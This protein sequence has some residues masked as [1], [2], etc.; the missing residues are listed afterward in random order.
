ML[1]R[2]FVVLA[3]LGSAAG[4]TASPKGKGRGAAAGKG[5]GKGRGAPAPVNLPE[6]HKLR[7]EM[8]RAWCT[9]GRNAATAP[10]QMEAFMNK[11][12][13]ESDPLKKKAMTTAHVTEHAEKRN[14]MVKVTP[15]RAPAGCPGRLG[16][17]A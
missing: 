14:R 1:A 9:G 10:C 12:K 6:L 2:T 11:V 7:D 8:R 15:Y 4:Q 5:V 13:G 17:T 16:R 3:L